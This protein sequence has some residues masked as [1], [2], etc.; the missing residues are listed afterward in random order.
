MTRQADALPPFSRAIMRPSPF[1]IAAD[2]LQSEAEALMS[3]CKITAP[4]V[5]DERQRMAGVVKSFHI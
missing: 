3:Q 5:I 1:C 2:A 4:L